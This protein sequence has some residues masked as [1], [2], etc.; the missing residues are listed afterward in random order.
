MNA[1]ESVVCTC[2]T[3]ETIEQQ[4]PPKNAVANMVPTD[5]A[6][7]VKIQDSENGSDIMVNSRRRPYCKND[8]PNIAPNKAPVPEIRRNNENILINCEHSFDLK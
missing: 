8:P 1:R 6:N 7:T 3:I 5:L 2:V 4:N